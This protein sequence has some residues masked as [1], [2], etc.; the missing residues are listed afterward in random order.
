MVGGVAVEARLWSGWYGCGSAVENMKVSRVEQVPFGYL[1][2]GFEGHHPCVVTPPLFVEPGRMTGS[3]FSASPSW[4]TGPTLRRR[5]VTEHGQSSAN[6]A[7][8]D[9]ASLRGRLAPGRPRGSTGR[10]P[11]SAAARQDTRA[12]EDRR[13]V[14]AG[15]LHRGGAA[16]R[17]LPGRAQQRREP[18]PR[19]PRYRNARLAPGNP[20]GHAHASP[21]G[22]V[23][24]PA[25]CHIG[26]HGI[27]GRGAPVAVGTCSQLP[28]GRRR[29]VLPVGCPGAAWPAALPGPVRAR[30]NS[31]SACTA[32][33]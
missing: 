2:E 18:D 9:P 12:A 28:G 19:P 5:R 1:P 23:P 29:R 25:H 16:D 11:C 27:A 14:R 32:R 17:R 3:L 22:S 24:W 15:R 8:P 30:C 20:C 4:C 7:Q 26:R 31:A 6:P 33:A 21:V 13:G 10:S